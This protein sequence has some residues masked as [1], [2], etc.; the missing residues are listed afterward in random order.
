YPNVRDAVWEWIKIHSKKVAEIYQ[1][2]GIFGRVMADVIPLLGI[3]RVEEVERFF[4]AN[5]IEGAEKGIRQGI[6]ILKAVSR[7]V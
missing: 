5:P 1:G 3:G 2:T 4:E 6:E 7:I